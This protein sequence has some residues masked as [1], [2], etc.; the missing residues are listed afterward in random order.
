MIF[1]ASALLLTLALRPVRRL[2]RHGQA[3]RDDTFALSE[4]DSSQKAASYRS[5]I[6]EGLTWLRREPRVRLQCGLIS[7]FAFCQALGLAVVVIYCTRVLHLSAASFGLFTAAAASGNTIGAWA[8]PR[9]HR[10]LGSGRTL[11][12]AGVLGGLALTLL[13]LTSAVG[14][15]V[16]ALGAEAV[17]VGVGRV[18]DAALRQQLVP[19]ELAGRVSSAVR[20]AVVGSATIATLVGGTLVV[21]LGPHAPFL[22]GGTGQILA[23]LFIGGALARR[24]AAD[25]RRVVDLTETVD[26][27]DSVAA[28]ENQR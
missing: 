5:Q 9:V 13:G 2:G 22:I 28:S 26:L 4:P 3:R 6:R 18:A 16:L 14:I 7:S 10:T 20:S 15:A 24:L 25:H 23:A 21:L 11:I 17:A 1:A 19:L 8:A 12:A 27:T